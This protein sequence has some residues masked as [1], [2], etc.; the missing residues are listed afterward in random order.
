MCSASVRN[1]EHTVCSKTLWFVHEM[2]MVCH[3]VDKSTYP[4]NLDM[5]ATAGLGVNRGGDRAGAMAT[6]VW[7]FVE[8]VCRLVGGRL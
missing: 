8:G 2:R 1:S 7:A 3:I 4:K 5:D 6:V